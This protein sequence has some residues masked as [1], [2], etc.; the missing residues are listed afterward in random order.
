MPGPES[1]SILCFPPFR[2][3]LFGTASWIVLFGR[4]EVEPKLVFNNA[5]AYGLIVR[6]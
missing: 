6:A 4:P 5:S 1:I 3:F 2:V